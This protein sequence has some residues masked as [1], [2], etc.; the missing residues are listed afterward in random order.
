MA[1]QSEWL[2][3]LVAYLKRNRDAP[4]RSMPDATVILLVQR[5]TGYSLYGLSDTGESAGDTWHPTLEEAKE[6]AVFQYGV[7][8]TA[9]LEWGRLDKRI[10]EDILS[11]L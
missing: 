5:A 10:Q 3:V 6:Q 11:H 4:K 8:D 7:A 9:W 2:P 1:P